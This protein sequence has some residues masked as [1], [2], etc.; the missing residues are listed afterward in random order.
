MDPGGTT[1]NRGIS[2]MSIATVDRKS[3][4]L[5]SSHGSHLVCRLLLEKKKQ[6]DGEH[7]VDPRPPSIPA[8]YTSAHSA[9]CNP[10]R[11]LGGWLHAR[12]PRAIS[13]FFFFFNDSAPPDIYPLSLPGAFPI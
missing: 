7:A 8:D 13:F 6:D 5:N 9:R 2:L 3:T 1:F 12:A 4:R 10:A 11:G